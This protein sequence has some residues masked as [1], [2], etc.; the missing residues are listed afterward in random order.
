VLSHE[1]AVEVLSDRPSP[2]EEA[3][4]PWPELYDKGIPTLFE[5][6]FGNRSFPAK[7]PAEGSQQFEVVWCFRAFDGVLSPSAG[8]GVDR[9]LI[10]QV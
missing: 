7:V 8:L 2:E 9:K 3:P 5:K 10:D 1:D 6:A 4:K